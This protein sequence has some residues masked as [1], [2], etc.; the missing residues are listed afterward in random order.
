MRPKVA[1]A[2]IKYARKLP[3]IFFNKDMFYSNICLKRRAAHRENDNDEG[4]PLGEKIC[5]KSLFSSVLCLIIF[6]LLP[7]F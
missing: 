7:T 4:C 1:K 6:V 2:K 5:G 3:D